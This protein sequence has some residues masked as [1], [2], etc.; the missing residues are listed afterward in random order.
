VT[1]RRWAIVGCSAFSGEGLQAGM[2][3]LIEDVSSRIFMWE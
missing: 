3:W 1:D 2:D